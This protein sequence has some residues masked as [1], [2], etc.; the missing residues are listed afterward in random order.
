MWRKILGY[1]YNLIS[2]AGILL[3]LAGVSLMVIFLAIGIIAGLEN[4][5]LGI[6]IYFV[7]PGILVLGLILIPAGILHTRK[8]MLREGKTEVPLYPTLD[9][10]D[11][12][13]RHK[14]IFF[15]FATMFF[16][17]LLALAS[18]K[19]YHYTESTEFCGKLCHTVMEPE[20]TAWSNSPHAR[21]R[22]A[23]CHIGPGAEWFVKAKLSG[24]KQV[25]RV[26]TNS[27]PTPIETPIPNLRPARDT[28][29]GCHWPAKFYSGKAKSFFHYASDE[30]NTPREVNLLLNLGKTPKIP[31]AS[32]IHWHISSK[33]FYLARDA[34]R[35]DIPY[36]AVQG[37]DGTLTE[38]H[39]ADKPLSRKEI[40]KKAPR[41]MDC[42]DCHNR[43]SHIYHPPGKEMDESFVSGTI[44]TSLPYIRKVAVEL[45][46]Q[47]YK[48][49]AEASSAIAAGIRSYYAKNYPELSKTK[50]PAIER[51][52]TEV[53]KIYQRNYFPTMKVAWSTHADNIGHFYFPGCFRCH[54]GK[55][56]SSAGKVISKDCNLCHE[57]LDQ[58]QENIKPGTKVTGFIHP[59]DIGDALETTGCY[60]CHQPAEM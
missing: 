38:Y 16:L 9:L 20:Y 15:I 53:Q 1:S 44:D 6:L 32:G 42:I 10:N 28:C 47:E 18:I 50:A 46:A 37:K 4:P 58:K 43:P 11:R 33:V 3:A 48:T 12:H 52:V 35:Q 27:Y 19:G 39:D 41:L 31:H 8:K 49:T 34:K 7:F 23:E 56:R 5:Y 13:Q 17:L 14:A 40:N 59:I 54:D 21:V 2:L 51:A 45:L 36:I 24:L 55:H 57:V 30:Q 60:E 22:C 26:L 25:Y 29:E